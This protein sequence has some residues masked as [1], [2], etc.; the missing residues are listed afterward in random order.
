MSELSNFA[1]NLLLDWLMTDGTAT[2]PTAWYVGLYSA[3]PNDTGGGTEISGNGYARQAVTFSAGSG[4]A[5]AN[6]NNVDFTPSGGNWAEATHFGIFDASSGGNLLLWSPLDANVTA[7]NGVTYRFAIG[8]I[9]V[10]FSAGN[11]SDFAANLA[12]SWL[13]TNG[14]ATRPTAWYVSLH[15]SNNT[16]LSGNG[17]SRQATDWDAAASGATANTD[18]VTFGPA[19][20]SDWAAA[21]KWGVYDASTSGNQLWLDDL[22]AARTV[23]VGGSAPAAAGDFDLALD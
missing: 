22:A 21:A 11:L 2:R 16:E 13:L 8:D 23:T 4:R 15:Q 7:L 19:T 14:A 20:G 1:E 9:D 18:A 3:A 5:T 6:T 12:L 17:Y 10:S